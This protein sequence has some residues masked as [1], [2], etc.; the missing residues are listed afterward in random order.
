MEPNSRRIQLEALLP[1]MQRMRAFEDAAAL[2]EVG[3]VLAQTVAA[4]ARKLLR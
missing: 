4:A 3:R 2:E 1:M